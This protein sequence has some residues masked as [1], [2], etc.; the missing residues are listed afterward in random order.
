MDNG[1]PAVV[2]AGLTK[3]YGSGETLV[4]AV[5]AVDFEIDRGEFVV[6]LGP[7]GSGKTTTLNLIGAIEEPTSGSIRVD[8]VEVADLDLNHQTD[9]RRDKVGFIFQFYNLVPTLTALENVQLVAELATRDGAEERSRSRLGEVG[10][11]DRVDHFPGQMS[12]GEQQR[13]AIARALVKDPP[14]LLCDEPTGSLDLETGR[15][16]LA[17]LREVCD[18]GRT[19]LTV[20]HNSTIAEMADRVMRLRDGTLVGV[21]RQD[22]PRAPGELEW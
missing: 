6:L 7:S 9:F 2:V 10:L 18:Q 15:Q 11:G 1:I 20:T 17:L 4:R 5:R 21:E 13:V 19:V 8:D 22:A 12:G 16:V 14:V 3:S